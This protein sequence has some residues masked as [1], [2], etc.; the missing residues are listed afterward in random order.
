L[1]YI[2]ALVIALAALA[3]IALFLF[4]E[5]YGRLPG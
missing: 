2:L 3:L 5:E 4:R 1:W